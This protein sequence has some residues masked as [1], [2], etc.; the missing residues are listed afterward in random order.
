MWDTYT[1]NDNTANPETTNFSI[2][3]IHI[4]NLNRAGTLSISLKRRVVGLG[5]ESWNEHNE[6]NSH[7]FLLR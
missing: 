1:I 2:K 4:T 7:R 5:D 3:F 6:I